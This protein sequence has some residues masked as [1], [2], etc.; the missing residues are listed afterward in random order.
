[1]LMVFTFEHSIDYQ[2]NVNGH[3]RK[4]ASAAH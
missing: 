2:D 3:N 4:Y 1:M